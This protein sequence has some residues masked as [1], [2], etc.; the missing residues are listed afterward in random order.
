M[1]AERAWQERMG[2][3]AGAS[4][5]AVP[6][7]M[8]AQDPMPKNLLTLGL[9]RY[10]S[11]MIATIMG[12]IPTGGGNANIDS[13]R[14]TIPNM[15]PRYQKIFRPCHRPIPITS[16]IIPGIAPRPFSIVTPT[17]IAATPMRM[18]RAATIDT[19]K[20]FRTCRFQP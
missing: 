12:T 17:M 13:M 10:Q 15:R 20:A 5:R 16:A 9:T 4:R 14:Y 11:V 1:R 3:P 6:P 19:N 18:Y 7:F 2:A 8:D